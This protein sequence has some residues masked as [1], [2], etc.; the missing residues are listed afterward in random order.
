MAFMA[1]YTKRGATYLIRASVGYRADGTQVERSKTWR[2]DPK[3]TPTQLEKAL[4][5]QCVLF[6]DQCNSGAVRDGHIKLELFIDQYFIEYGDMA[7][8][9]RTRASYTGMKPRVNTALG[10]IYLDKLTPRQVKGF[11]NNM[12]EDGLNSRTGGKLASKTIQNY[13]TF[14]SAVCSYAIKMEMIPSNPCANVQ[15]PKDMKKRKVWYTLKETQKILDSL[16]S[17]PTMYR[18]I[19]ILAI[20]CGYRREELCGL[21]W[22]DIDFKRKLITI[23]RA[24]L[25]TPDK[26]I[27]TDTTKNEGSQRVA[28]QSDVVMQAL[29]KWRAEQAEQRLKLGDRWHDCGRVFTGTEG[30]PI[31]PNTP[32]TWLS[33]HCEKHGLR[34]LGLHA[35]R[36]FNAAALIRAGA[37][38]K[39]VSSLLGHMQ[40]STTLN[41]Y[42]YEFA[43]AQ[44]AAS[45][46]VSDLLTGKLKTE[47][48]DKQRTKRKKRA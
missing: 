28:K 18:T 4:N 33:R 41:T 43:E 47:T 12:G 37:D 36:H 19:L 22:G 5:R 20:F 38:V 17:A 35:F 21:E 34:F 23:Q 14:L 46:A 42:A 32:Y 40:T 15:V 10:H 26:G 48:T 1:Y 27:Y 11:I 13:L 31:H 44:A 7:L 30:K 29:R 16:Q 24:S 2:P 45:E 6:E 9:E 39:T 25:Y 3:L 8:R